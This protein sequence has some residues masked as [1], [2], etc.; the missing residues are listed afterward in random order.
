MFFIACYISYRRRLVLIYYLA[1]FWDASGRIVAGPCLQRVLAAVGLSRTF[2]LLAGVMSLTSFVAFLYKP[3][4]NG[5][6]NQ[7]TFETIE[8][9]K[10]RWFDLSVLKHKPYTTFVAATSI[11]TVAFSATYVHVVSKG[12]T[13]IFFG[14]GG[15]DEKYWKKLFAEPGKTK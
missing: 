12:R 6:E 11:L 5:E 15:G 10:N 3:T 13:I 2:L 14:G 4:A 8:N 1:L 7:E 9:K